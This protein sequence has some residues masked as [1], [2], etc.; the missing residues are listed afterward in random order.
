MKRRGLLTLL[1]CSLLIG[2]NNNGSVESSSFNNI[3]STSNNS[4]NI[5]DKS[6]SNANSSTSSSSINYSNS[7]SST[8][9][10]DNVEYEFNTYFNGSLPVNK[11]SQDYKGEI[12]DPSVVR[13][14]DGKFYVF[15][16]IRK[17]FVSEDMCNWELLN[18][19]IIP[20][21]TWAD[22]DVHGRPD[23]WAP[24]CIKI[25]DKW[26]YYYSLA[27]W[28][29]PSAGI[30][31]AVSDNIYGPY[32]DKGKLMNE[33]DVDIN[34]LIDPQPYIDTDGSIYMVVGSFHGNYLVELEDDGMSL[35][36][37]ASYQKEN[38]VLIAG[39]PLDYFDNTYYE[40]GYIVKKDEYYYFF[41][42]A[43]SC[44]EGL[45][46]SY[47]VVVGRANNIAGPY[48]S[49]DGRDLASRNFGTTIG[50]LCLW[51]PVTDNTTAGPGHNSILIDDAGD[52]WIIYH[53]YCDI[54]NFLTRHLFMDKLSWN[55]KGFP[56]VSYTYETDE[57][58]AKTVNYKP[59]Y[60][61]ELDGPRFIKGE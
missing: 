2:C 17:L 15:S 6:S 37:G 29:M 52:Y 22:G 44:C 43:G 25:K 33:E 28:D 46:S 45:N 9:I 54:D 42:S 51:S 59:S 41:G 61:I 1:V 18:E 53:S 21:P 55:D 10:E 11:N 30:G 31:Y 24:D 36:N 5:S 27:A 34:G 60:L 3:V 14:D 47:R 23:V 13:G 32:E 16:T 56:Y 48:Y 38:K 19:Q 12:A 8:I 4:T 57:G 7:V 26:I 35:K 39:I 50:D 40:G 58:K 49:S 20:R